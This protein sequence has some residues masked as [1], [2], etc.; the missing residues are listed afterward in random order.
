MSK[1]G[2]SSYLRAMVEQDAS[3]LHVTVGVPPEF[4]MRMRKS[5]KLGRP[6]LIKV[7]AT[8]IGSGLPMTDLNL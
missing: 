3:D 6:L 2:I 1:V 8:S 4:R 7:A 5:L